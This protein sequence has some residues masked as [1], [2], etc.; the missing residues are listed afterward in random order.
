[1]AREHCGTR[2][3]EIGS[4]G[5]TRTSDILINN[6]TG[7]GCTETSHDVSPHDLDGASV[8]RLP[9]D[10]RGSQWVGTSVEPPCAVP[11]A[12]VGSAVRSSGAVNGYAQLWLRGGG[13]I[14]VAVADHTTKEIPEP[15]RC[16]STTSRS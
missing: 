3:R 12:S 8:G 16:S 6:P 10:R 7:S 15:S 1:M 14:P 2:K 4:P 13:A 9:V 5:W 11:W